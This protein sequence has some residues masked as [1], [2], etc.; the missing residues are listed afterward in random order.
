MRLMAAGA[1]LHD[2]MLEFGFLQEVIVAVPAQRRRGLF[3]QRLSV[4]SVGIMAFEAISIRHR[5][6]NDLGI[7]GGNI[8]VAA[9][10]GI[11]DRFLE[12][13]FDF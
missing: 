1:I 8:I 2:V 12:Q 11:F 5:L 6:M 3:N 13:A 9:R 4:R 10:T 7:L